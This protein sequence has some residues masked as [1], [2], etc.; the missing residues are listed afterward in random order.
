MNMLT[1]ATVH[2]QL[3]INDFRAM[4]KDE[5]GVTAVEYAILAVA[6]S[7]MVLAVFVTDAAG[8]KSA[9]TG[10][11]ATITTNITNANP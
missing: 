10:A 3:W 6:M 11:I 8:L 4:L 2:T 5:R 1:K 9:L 7:A